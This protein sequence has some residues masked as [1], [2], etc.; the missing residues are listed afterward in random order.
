MSEAKRIQ[1]AGSRASHA[2]RMNAD[3]SLEPKSAAIRNTPSPFQ[4]EGWDGG[5]M[6]A[7]VEASPSDPHPNPLPGRGRESRAG[8]CQQCAEGAKISAFGLRRKSR[9]FA[10]KAHRACAIYVCLLLSG[11]LDAIAQAL[12]PAAVPRPPEPAAPTPAPRAPE[13]VTPQRPGLSGAPAL[14]VRVE[15]FGISGNTLVPTADIDAVLTP[16]VG[17]TLDF[18]QLTE[19]ADAVTNLY[20]RRGWLLALAYLPEQQIRDG[21]VEIAVLEGRL[22]KLQLGSVDEGLD[23]GFAQAAASWHLAEGQAVGEANLVRNLLVINDQPGLAVNAEVR[24]G[25]AVGSADVT[26]DVHRLGPNLRGSVVLDNHGS[27]FTGRGRLGATVSALNLLGRGDQLDLLALGTQSNGQQSG[28]AAYSLPVHASG[29]RLGVSISGVKYEIVDSGLRDLDA[30]GSAWSGQLAL[31]QPLS[32]QLDY[33]LGL[34]L[35]FVHKGLRDRV[36]AFQQ[37]NDRHIDAVQL[38]LRGQW[39]PA[40]LPGAVT[41]WSV[42]ATH[43]RVRFDDESA[44]TVDSD[45]LRTKGTYTRYNLDLAHQQPL[46]ERL[47]LLGRLLLQ[48]ASKNLDAAERVVIGGANALRPFGDRP[49]SAD[50]AALF[51]LDLRYRIPTTLVPAFAV[52]AFAD[53]AIGRAS[54][55]PAP[56]AASNRLRGATLGLS[57][58]ATLPYDTTLRLAVSRQYADPRDDGRKSWIW[59]GWI[60]LIKTF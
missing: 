3:A 53:Y 20:R 17:R 59:R 31:D 43:G 15:R 51:G 52:G 1:Q 38:G 28:L 11:P 2:G 23:R 37:R 39:R 44:E 41:D 24:P 26:V 16:F 56:D 13:I 4:G 47:S 48:A 14:S 29:T 34:R 21:K 49:V 10:A 42:S 8:T 33:A 6:N 25:S 50:E 40:G 36:D 19:A 27:R 60:E 54:R 7:I 45:T 5:Q 12:P 57:A 55:N 22:G 35:L 32:R 46:T 58:D 18:R 9:G 30:N